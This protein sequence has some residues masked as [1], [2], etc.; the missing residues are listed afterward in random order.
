MKSIKSFL[1]V[2]ALVIAGVA[3][4]AQTADDVIAKHLDAIGGKDKLNQI[5]SVVYTGSVTVMG[6]DGP[7]TIT[8]VP[9]KGYKSVTSINGQD[10]VQTI[11]DKGGW[12]INPFQGGTDAQAMPDDQYKGSETQLF[13]DPFL[14]YAAHGSKVEL[15]GTEG[16]AYKIVL[17]NK[18]GIATTYYIDTTTYYISK[19]VRTMNMMGND[20]ELTISFSDYK[21]TD[22]GTTS[23]Y[24]MEMAF[25]S[26]FS[27]TSTYKTITVNGTVD[28]KIFDM[29]K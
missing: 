29:P 2:A 13:V 25:G 11:T 22:F 6:N 4:K 18:D 23:A 7:S 12:M 20:T 3:A 21:K 5:T 1:S 14:D 16:G 15:K 26:Q 28:P 24:S 9:G 27:M 19:A 17:T 10:L 8:L